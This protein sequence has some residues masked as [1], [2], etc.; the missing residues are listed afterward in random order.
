MGNLSKEATKMNITNKTICYFLIILFTFS[1]ASLSAEKQ[2]QAH[3]EHKEKHSDH[4]EHDKGND[5]EKHD[6]HDDEPHHE[7]EKD[8]EHAEDDKHGHGEAETDVELNQKQR[9]QA[10]IETMPL[11]EQSISDQITALGE[12]KLN[13]YRTINVSPSITTRVEK[14]HVY[15]GDQVK[16]GDLLATLHTIST[17]DISANVLAT[18]DLAA[19]SAELAASIAEAKGELAA[20]N[21]TWQ[22][23]QSLGR[24]A[25]SGK[26]YTAARIAKEQ[27]QAKLKAYG[28]SQSHVKN[29]IKSGSKSVQKLFDLRA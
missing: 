29:L 7:S 11:I 26:R 24:D 9:K 15:L 23:I 20:A 22:R 25:V 14:R 3:D 16:K 19:S 17:T 12:V 28:K 21:A 10:G 2:A 5:K 4:K 13:Q 6:D 1:S 18:A 27:A 8:N